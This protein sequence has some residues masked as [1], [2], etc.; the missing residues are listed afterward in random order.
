MVMDFL[1]TIRDTVHGW[2]E[3]TRKFLAMTVMGAALIA[4]FVIWGPNVSS[5]LVAIGLPPVAPVA[6]NNT[7]FPSPT[8]LLPQD[9]GMEGGS[10]FGRD[11]TAALDET[12]PQDQPSLSQPLASGQNPFP[13]PQAMQ[14]QIQ[15]EQAPTPVQGMAE[16]FSGLNRLF[17]KADNQ[18]SVGTWAQQTLD[19]LS[20]AIRRAA[21]YVLR[22]A[23][24]AMQDFLFWLEGLAPQQ[25]PAFNISHQ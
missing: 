19:E 22:M 15:P 11:Q 4:F 14:E 16:T 5:H 18:A 20:E 2:P 25:F 12:Q 24:N 6:D 21:A 8:A 3:E 7:R 13:P 9:S 1:R 10:A 17:A 23:R